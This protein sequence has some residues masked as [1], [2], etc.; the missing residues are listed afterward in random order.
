M[1]GQIRAI[2]IHVACE[3]APDSLRRRAIEDSLSLSN[4]GPNAVAEVFVL[5]AGSPQRQPL[6]GRK[7]CAGRGRRCSSGV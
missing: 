3:F 1:L 7:L 6:S 2:M 4:T 5:F